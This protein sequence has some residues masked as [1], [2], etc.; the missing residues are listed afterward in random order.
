MGGNSLP[1][2]AVRRSVRRL[3]RYGVFLVSMLLC[4][5]TAAYD[6]PLHQQFTFIAAKQLNRCLE[7][8]S[9]PRLTPLQVR[10]IAKSD[11]AQAQGSWIPQ[12]HW[13]YYDRSAQGPKKLLW[14]VDT[15]LHDHFRQLEGEMASAQEMSDQYSD[16]GYIVNYLQNMTSP[17]H[18]VPVYFTRWWR[19]SLADRFD[20]YPI[21]EEAL[22]R[23]LN[24]DC[25]ALLEGPEQ[26]VDEILTDTASAT[27]R[28]VQR[29]IDALPVTWQAFWKLADDPEQFGEYGR[30][31]NNFGRRV[32]FKCG[33]TKCVLLD[34]D[35]L[36]DAFALERHVD[37]VN[38][39][40]R[41][42]LWQ[43]R[44]AASVAH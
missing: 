33:D 35:P 25:A 31:G 14:V 22:E 11:V 38:A 24:T 13:G 43:Q 30:A 42:M 2:C 36:Y 3:F 20:G 18:V 34:K 37:A 23:A 19:F 12:M 15:R 9:I 4:E 7:G 44:R 21:D 16:L 1:D 41:A 17:A 5:Y 8:S 32:E 39:T 27:L 10:Y 29:R 28:A 40:M 26:P 6:P